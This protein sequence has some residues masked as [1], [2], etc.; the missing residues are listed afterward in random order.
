MRKDNER[1]Y[2]LL[3]AGAEAMCFVG[4]VRT[5]PDE[6]QGGMGT[7]RSVRSQG[8]GLCPLADSPASSH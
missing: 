5:D 1:P 4:D 8:Q 2:V 6:R 3:W 7:R